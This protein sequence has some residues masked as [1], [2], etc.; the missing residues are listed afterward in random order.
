MAEFLKFFWRKEKLQKLRE[1]KKKPRQGKGE[2]SGTY[3][4][5]STGSVMAR[6]MQLSRIVV[7]T[8]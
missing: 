1:L 3:S 7:M 8:T 4:A 5:C 2:R 6:K